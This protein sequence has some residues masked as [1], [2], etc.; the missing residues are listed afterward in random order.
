VNVDQENAI[1]AE[2]GISSIPT[3][4]LFSKGKEVARAVGVQRDTDLDSMLSG[5]N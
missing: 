2:F 4:I 3:L 5:A 1:A